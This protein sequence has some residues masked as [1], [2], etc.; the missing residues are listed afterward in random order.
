RQPRAL[1][2]CFVDAASTHKTRDDLRRLANRQHPRRVRVQLRHHIAPQ[3]QESAD[4]RLLH[5]PQPVRGPLPPHDLHQVVP[6]LVRLARVEPSRVDRIGVEHV[7]AELPKEMLV[8]RDERR[9]L[10]VA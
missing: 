7:G 2:A 5:D 4:A 10:P 1:G 3:R 6:S 9:R 8:M